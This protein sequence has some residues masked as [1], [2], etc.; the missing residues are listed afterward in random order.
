MEIHK[1]FSIPFACLVFGLIGLG[2]GASN[3]RDGKLASF[4]LGIAV[5]FVYY[6]LLWLG[7]A[8]LA[9]GVCATGVLRLVQGPPPGRL[10][11]TALGVAVGNTSEALLAAILL[12]RFAQGANVFNRTRN[13]LTFVFLAGIISTAAGA[14]MGATTL[15]LGG[16]IGGNYGFI[17][18][19]GMVPVKFRSVLTT[20]GAIGSRAYAAGTGDVGSDQGTADVLTSDATS[21]DNARYL[22][23]AVSAP[24]GDS[25]TP[26]LLGFHNIIAGN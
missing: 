18:D 16:F 3:R 6:V 12:A 9:L 15:Y 25:L 11:W 21:L 26:V 8:I 23:N 17:Q 1:K 19:L 20:A 2:L 14:T 7:Q 13:I 22:G 24:S 4:V 5:I 10:M